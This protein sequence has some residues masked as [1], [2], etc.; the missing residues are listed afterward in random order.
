M[1]RSIKFKVYY[2]GEVYFNPCLKFYDSEVQLFIENEYTYISPS[3]VCQY[4]GLKDKNGVEIYEGSVVKMHDFCGHNVGEV[5]HK[6]YYSHDE[7]APS[8]F[9]Y[10]VGNVLLTPDH[11]V[12]VI[13]NIYENKELL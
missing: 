11:D 2:K 13:G 10:H 9:G 12:E 1:K 7:Y 6:Y 4:T 3:N 5:L 8:T